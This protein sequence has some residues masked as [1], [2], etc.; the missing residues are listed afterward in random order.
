MLKLF[1][2]H[3]STIESAVPRNSNI[4]SQLS[5]KTRLTM[6]ENPSASLV[7]PIVCE[8]NEATLH[9]V[10]L[11]PFPRNAI[12]ALLLSLEISGLKVFAN[13]SAG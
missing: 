2:C 4:L 10:F 6:R 1:L 8:N 5:T 12:C 9:T 13:A 3:S 7:D 11:G